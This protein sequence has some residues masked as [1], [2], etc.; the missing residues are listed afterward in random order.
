MLQ[1]YLTFTNTNL[2]YR[3]YWINTAIWHMSSDWLAN[4]STQYIQII[5]PKNELLSVLGR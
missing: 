3:N 5:S 1:T 2:S 4:C